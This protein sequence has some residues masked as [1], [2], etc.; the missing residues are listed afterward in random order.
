MHWA[1]YEHFQQLGQSYNRNAC[2]CW[3]DK[4]PQL[5]SN[6][7][8]WWTRSRFHINSNWFSFQELFH[9]PTMQY[10]ALTSLHFLGWSGYLDRSHFRFSTIVFRNYFQ[11]SVVD[12][13]MLQ[14][15]VRTHNES[16]LVW[17]LFD[18]LRS[19]RATYCK[20]HLEGPCHK[21][22]KTNN[23]GSIFQ[24]TPLRGFWI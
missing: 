18:K 13:I 19:S 4:L 16:Q 2:I 17:G 1:K 23:H 8:H 12:A 6:F 21:N 9:Q 24:N 22:D 15:W 3:R 20:R 5:K 7:A 11:L 14:F 10:P